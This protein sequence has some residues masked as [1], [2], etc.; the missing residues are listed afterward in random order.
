MRFLGALIALL[1][2]TSGSVMAARAL[3]SGQPGYALAAWFTHADGTPC[4][5]PCMFGLQPGITPYREI[6]PLLRAHPV[7]RDFRI[8][9]TFDGSGVRLAGE[10]FFVTVYSGSRRRVDLLFVTLS[11]ARS[12]HTL[13]LSAGQ[14]INALGPPDV[15]QIESLS[16][17]RFTGMLYTGCNLSLWLPDG[18][19]REVNAYTRFA[20]VGMY[21]TLGLTAERPYLRAWR[22]F[23]EIQ[24]YLQRAAPYIDRETA[25]SCAKG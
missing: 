1:V 23:G 21:G 11:N 19:H 2:A 10:S 6:V 16:R 22:G 7:T 17:P 24:R 15:L 13:P 25:S 5:Q 3:G 14:V 9:S 8:L 4:E 20:F 12:G 18:D